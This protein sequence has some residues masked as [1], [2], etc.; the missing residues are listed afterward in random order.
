[1]TLTHIRK[2]GQINL[3]DGWIIPHGM[4]APLKSACDYSAPLLEED[5]K[6]HPLHTSP[7][8]HFQSLHLVANFLLLLAQKQGQK[9]IQL[10]DLVCIVCSWFVWRAEGSVF[11]KPPW[12]YNCSLMKCQ[13]EL[14]HWLHWEQLYVNARLF[15]GKK[16]QPNKKT[17]KS[18]QS[19]LSLKWCLV[20]ALQSDASPRGAGKNAERWNA[21]FSLNIKCRKQ[22][23]T[24]HF[25][26]V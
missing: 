20:S 6:I 5:P 9:R 16:K 10:Q 24:C 1:M 15:L 4:T 11:K 21:E 14:Y 12:H 17:T 23:V 3:K 18:P 8:H 22:P 7:H 13:W 26:S 2:Q 19:L 25:C